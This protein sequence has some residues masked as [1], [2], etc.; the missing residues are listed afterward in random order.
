MVGSDTNSY[1][2]RT[3]LRQRGSSNQ[4]MVKKGDTNLRLGAFWVGLQMVAAGWPSHFGHLGH[5][6]NRTSKRSACGCLRVGK[7]FGHKC[8]VLGDNTVKPC[9]WL[10]S[11]KWDLAVATQTHCNRSIVQY[12]IKYWH[13][14]H[15]I[16]ISCASIGSCVGIVL[17]TLITNGMY[18]YCLSMTVEQCLWPWLDVCCLSS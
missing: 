17:Q 15:A 16:S 14:V 18:G 6:C 1:K 4:Q 3:W 8:L 11:V 7:M 5:I 12:V 10:Y 13:Y 9:L 2:Y